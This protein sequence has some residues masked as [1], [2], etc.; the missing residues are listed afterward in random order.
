M[1]SLKLAVL[2]AVIL[3]SCNCLQAQEIIADITC[4][5]EQVSSIQK[6]YLQD[7]DKKLMDYI[8]NYR[9]IGKNYGNDKV[10][11]SMSILFS[12]TNSDN[13]YSARVVI[14][15]T[16]PLFDG[17]Q[18]RNKST[19]MMRFLDERWDF[20]YERGQILTHEERMFNPLTS[21]I[22]FYMLIVL[23]YDSDS[24]ETE[25]GGTPLFE[26]ARN[27]VQLAP[28]GVVGWKKVPGTSYSKWD[29]SE[30]LINVTLLPVRSAFFWR[31]ANL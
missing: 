11:V 3:L 12:Q 13:S 28:S 1:K 14:E 8:N 27:I 31:R 25:F 26:R 17:E 16:R 5:Y 24:Y 4:N 6:D 23:G 9:W 2:T 10:R 15:S 21:F 22:D 19:K 30:E 18:S 7:F 20:Y 29:L